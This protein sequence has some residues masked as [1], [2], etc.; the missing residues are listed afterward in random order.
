MASER[1]L[2]EFCHDSPESGEV[3]LTVRTVN[4]DHSSGRGAS[5][6]VVEAVGIDQR[7]AIVQRL[8]NT[9]KGGIA[10]PG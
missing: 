9:E 4:M 3:K 7:A 10:P 6:S 2:S 8:N 1:A 5:H